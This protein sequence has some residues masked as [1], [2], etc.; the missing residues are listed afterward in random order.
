MVLLTNYAKDKWIKLSNQKS[1]IGGIQRHTV[2]YK[3]KI[4]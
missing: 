2:D 3:T 4:I 1:N